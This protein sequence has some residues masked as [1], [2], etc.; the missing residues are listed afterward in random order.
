[1][2]QNLIEDI[3]NILSERYLIGA[4]A[5]E[6]MDFVRN[7]AE[8]NIY[9]MAYVTYAIDLLTNDTVDD[10]IDYFT[11]DNIIKE[12]SASYSD[13]DVKL[14]ILKDVYKRQAGW[15]STLAN[16]RFSESINCFSKA[17]TNAPE[18]KID[19]IKK[20]AADEIANLSEALIT[21][22]CN[23]FINYCSTDNAN[24]ILNNVLETK[25]ISIAF[26]IKCDITAT[27]YE[28]TVATKINAAV[29]EAWGGTILP[30]YNGDDGHPSKYEWETFKD[31][32]FSCIELLK[33][34]IN[35]SDSD[36]QEDIQRY[37]NLVLIT[38]SLV[39]SC[40]WEQ[41]FNQYGSTWSKEWS[42][43]AEAKQANIDNLMTY[44]QKIKELDP[45]YVIPGRPAPKGNGCYVATAVYGSYDCP[46][47]WTLRRYRDNKLAT[48]WHGKMFIKAY[49]AISPTI[50]KYFGETKWFNKFWKARLDKMVANLQ[51]SGFEST[52]YCDKLL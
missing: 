43:T 48:S 50:V 1:M 27:E 40:S 29:C 44:H 7:I 23:N 25:E 45:T 14:L 12:L 47:V 20:E 5:N 17:I 13:N 34:S 46:Q 21:M 18:E 37:K 30:E 33:C 41:S 16:K 42:L 4:S 38:Q 49:Y 24:S 36:S 9:L 22:C 19:E 28:E 8:K 39:D 32:C 15:Q 11:D 52:N 6:L 2:D 35:I 26:L 31:R 51:N 10:R 3:F